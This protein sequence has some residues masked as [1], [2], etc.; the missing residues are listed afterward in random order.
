MA[1]SSVP[2]AFFE[3][4][5][6]NPKAKVVP[7]MVAFFSEDGSCYVNA[8]APGSGD[9]IGLLQELWN[10][11]IPEGGDDL[12]YALLDQIED[13]TSMEFADF[14]LDQW[15]KKQERRDLVQ[16]AHR[17]DDWLSTI[18]RDWPGALPG[19]DS[20]WLINVFSVVYAVT[21]QKGDRDHALGKAIEAVF[22]YGFQQ[23]RENRA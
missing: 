1:L 2:L 16:L 7:G 18:P 21:E 15:D 12:G 17:V 13:M 5:S 4:L 14:V 8:D 3:R 11:D 10:L 20:E 22:M 19:Y 6:K 23:G 9:L